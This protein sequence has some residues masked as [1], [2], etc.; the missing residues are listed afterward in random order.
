[1]GKPIT[2]SASTQSVTIN[3][4]AKPTPSK[5]PFLARKIRKQTPKIT[6][7]AIA[8]DSAVD[9]PK[10]L[11]YPGEIAT[12]LN[13]LK[14]SDPLLATLIEAH[15]PPTFES[16]A[17]PF[18]SLAKS[19]LHQ[20]LATGAARTIF[21]RFLALCGGESNVLP[22]TVLSLT[23]Q[24]LRE[25]GVSGMKASYLHDLSEKY[26]N[27]SL[28][29]SLILAMDDEKLM[30]SLTR[31]KGIG[32]W[33]VHMFMMFSLHRSDVLPAGDLGVRKGVQAL[34]GLKGLP[35]GS[36]ME[37]IC[38]KWKP[39]RSVGSWYMWRLMEASKSVAKKTKSSRSSSS[40]SSSKKAGTS[41][42]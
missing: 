39:Y 21:G 2:R 8:V 24:Q 3:A 35:E 41:K 5:I 28:S 31:V 23:P 19:I 40:S 15:K 13:H 16:Q 42:K 12:A 32:V 26:A 38:E 29:D 37:R 22:E 36:E 10:P 11:S 9:K 18:L 14:S 6:A 25:I 27:G 30:E 34:N 17:P 7:A 1:M 33:S 4:A 20:Q